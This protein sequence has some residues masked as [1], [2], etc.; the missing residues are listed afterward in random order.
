MVVEGSRGQ[1]IDTATASS[2]FR[3]SRRS[4]VSFEHAAV[5]RVRTI[6]GAAGDQG[7]PGRGPSRRARLQPHRPVWCIRVDAYAPGGSR[8]DRDRA[9]LNR[10]GTSMADLQV[11]QAP[12]ARR[13][14]IE[15]PL[16]ALAAGEYVVELNAKTRRRKLGAG[17]GRVQSR[18]L[19]EVDSSER[20]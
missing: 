8:P 4:Q 13:G 19:D 3:T 15:L 10:T 11:Q 6:R 7:K 18:P 17:A 14:E 16:S 2:P 1:V 9:A 20:S 12:A 5:F